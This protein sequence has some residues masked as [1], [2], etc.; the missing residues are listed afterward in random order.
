MSPDQSPDP[1]H[2][3]RWSPDFHITWPPLIVLTAY[4]LTAHCLPYMGTLLSLGLLSCSPLFSLVIVFVPIVL[5]ALLSVSLGHLVMV[6]A[7]VVYKPSL[8][9]RRGLKPDLVSNPSVVALQTLPVCFSPFPLSHLSLGRLKVPWDSPLPSYL[10]PKIFIL[11]NFI[12]KHLPSSLRVPVPCDSLCRQTNR[13]CCTLRPLD[14]NTSQ[15]L[16]DPLQRITETP[17]RA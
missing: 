7:S 10:S 8:Y 2:M 6:A 13:A 4:C 5:R 17:W 11:W 14:L 12:S 3:T 15:A 16:P 9:H 1:C